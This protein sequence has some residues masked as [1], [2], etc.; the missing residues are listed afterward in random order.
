MIGMFIAVA[1]GTISMSWNRIDIPSLGSFALAWH[2]V[3]GAMVAS[4]FTLPNWHLLWYVLPVL[5]ILRRRRFRDDPAA[6]SL[7]LDAADRLRIPV[8]AV[9]L[10]DGVGL[11]AGFHEREPADPAARAERARARGGAAAA[12]RR[13]RRRIYVRDA[14]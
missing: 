1:V 10:H 5:L 8:R 4:L 9:L 13:K 11:G 14:S 12:D 6:R 2:G 7:G 3:G